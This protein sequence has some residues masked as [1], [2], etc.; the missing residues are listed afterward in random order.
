MEEEVTPCQSNRH[1][2]MI[3][4]FTALSPSLPRHRLP[5]NNQIKHPNKVRYQSIRVWHCTDKTIGPLTFQFRAV[6]LGD[7]T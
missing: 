7:I 2:E 3:F 5:V 1:G 4:S 6:F